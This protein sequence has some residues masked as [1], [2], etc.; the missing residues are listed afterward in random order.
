MTKIAVLV[1]SLSKN[2]INKKLANALES[3]APEGV[4][5]TAVDVDLP[6]YN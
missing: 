4:E 5:F 2:S 6:L 1:G 3:V